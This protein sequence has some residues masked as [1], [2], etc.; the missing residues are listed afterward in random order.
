M[1]ITDIEQARLAKENKMRHGYDYKIESS[2][3]RQRK[4]FV[5]HDGSYEKNILGIRIEVPRSEDKIPSIKSAYN[6]SN[7]RSRSA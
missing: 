1:H 3:D 4:G 7:S 5:E 6:S 2:E